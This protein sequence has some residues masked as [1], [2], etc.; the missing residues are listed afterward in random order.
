[1]KIILLVSVIVVPGLFL[2]KF[3]ISPVGEQVEFL[4]IGEIWGHIGEHHMVIHLNYSPLQQNMDNIR[5]LCEHI[6]DLKKTGGA[7]VDVE[8]EHA[9][10]KCQWTL[11]RQ[12]Q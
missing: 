10:Q 6:K 3:D 5:T 7:I 2:Q 12:E 8:I 1:M 11:M 9:D 4:K